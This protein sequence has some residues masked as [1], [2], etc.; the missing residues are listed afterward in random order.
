MIYFVHQFVPEP[1]RSLVS[2]QSLKALLSKG[3][4]VHAFDEKGAQ[5]MQKLFAVYF[6]EHIFH[7][8]ELPPIGGMFYLWT[9][10]M[11]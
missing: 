1:E 5:S 4:P 3:L 6:P 10:T 11:D 2:R 9:T 8:G 7:V